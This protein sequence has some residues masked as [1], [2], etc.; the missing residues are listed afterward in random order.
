LLTAF[1]SRFGVADLMLISFA[2][3]GAGNYA[4]LKYAMPEFPVYVIAALRFTIS[5]LILLVVTYLTEGSL[6]L[7]SGMWS[8]IGLLGAGGIF[9]YQIF[10]A[11][12]IEITS[13]VNTALM[14]AMSPIFTTIYTAFIKKEMLS[15][16]VILGI[17]LGFLG[18]ILISLGQTGG[19]V[20]SLQT[21]RGDLMVMVAAMFWSFYGLLNQEVLKKVSVIKMTAYAMLFGG[22][23][24]WMV[25]V[26]DL[27]LVN[28]KNISLNAW[29]GLTYS[30]LIAACLVFVLWAF[31]VKRI[32]TSRAIVYLYLQPFIAMI[33]GITLL[34]EQVTWFQLLGGVIIICGII[35]VR[36]E[37][38]E[39]RN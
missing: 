34:G 6:A 38:T 8:K 12:G 14:V 5:A 13:T 7:P 27:P 15:R 17:L 11:K 30:T 25:A 4:A 23:L 37:N 10:F 32:G 28:W 22:I 26:K 35:K 33:I 16:S 20:V 31:G 1:K 29:L 39:F 24:L 36:R 19:L 2:T 3:L 9:G 18:A 21:A